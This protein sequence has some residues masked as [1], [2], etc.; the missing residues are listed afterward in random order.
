MINFLFMTDPHVSGTRPST[1]TDDFPETI[2]RKI[3]N[4]FEVGAQLGV[5]FYL[6]GGD[7]VNSALTSTKTVEKLGVIFDKHLKDKGKKMYMIW[8]NHDVFSYNPN[9]AIDT[10][11]GLHVRFSD[12]IEVVDRQPTTINVNGVNVDI[13]GVHSYARL[14]KD[15]ED[16]HGNIIRTKELDYI[17]KKTNP[18]IHMVHGYLSTK[19]RLEDIPHTLVENILETE[20]DFTLT[21]HEHTGFPIIEHDGKII[22]NP[23]SLGRVFAS[24]TEMKR[25]PQFFHGWFDDDMKPHGQLLQCKIAVDGELVFNRQLLDEQKR[26][27]QILKNMQQD[28]RSSLA[29]IENIESISLIDVVDRLKDTVQPD[30]YKEAKRRLE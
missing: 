26:T 13:S 27:E 1:R 10:A 4:F 2:L 28:L 14:D 21:G 20:A 8:G 6:C 7:I 22:C 19:E 24:H 16:E 15:V 9:T 18:R 25:M 23:G 11:L 29:S 5:D 30:I 17:V 3:E 12:S